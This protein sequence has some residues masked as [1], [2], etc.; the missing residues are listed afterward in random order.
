MYCWQYIRLE[1]IARC[2]CDWSLSLSS[3]GSKTCF[4]R[5]HAIDIKCCRGQGDEAGASLSFWEL[6]SGLIVP[7]SSSTSSVRG[8]LGS[9][10]SVPLMTTMERPFPTSD[11]QVWEYG[12]KWPFVELVGTGVRLSKYYGEW[13]GVI[14]KYRCFP[15]GTV[16]E[17]GL[18][19]YY[20]VTK[21]RLSRLSWGCG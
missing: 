2:I 7:S 3:V 6:S 15:C 17:D 20:F 19:E 9:Q 1:S 18:M 11:R 14:H 21:Y 10:G 12:Y 5:A 4:R 8:K 13:A 16:T